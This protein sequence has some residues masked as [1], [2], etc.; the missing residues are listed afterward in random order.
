MSLLGGCITYTIIKFLSLGLSILSR[1][2]SIKLAKFLGSL[3]NKIFPKR[4]KVAKKN[5]QIAFPNKSQSE[6]DNIIKLT[7]QHYI[8][9]MFEFLRQQQLKAKNIKITVDSK[10]QEILSS[11]KGLILMT[12]HIGNWEMIIPILS[13]YKKSTVVVKA[14]RNKGGNKFLNE[15]RN[16]KNIT[17]LSMKSSKRVMID[18]L[19]NGEALALASDQNAEDKGIKIPFFGLEASIP[20]GAAY[21]HYKT[22]CPIAV[23]FCILKKDFSYEFKLRNIDINQN[24]DNTEDL[25]FS[26]HQMYASLLEQ[27]IKKNPEQYFWFHRKWNRELYN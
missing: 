22:K 24:F 9:L 21:F 1:G 23:G 15:T 14:Q 20:K 2:G 27:E 17:L 12:A 18:A 3:I 8:I 13:Q 4:K 26:I 5:L 19:I 25:F 16:F 7:Y 11:N 6:I 10:T